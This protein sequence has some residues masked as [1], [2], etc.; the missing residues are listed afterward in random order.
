MT[1]AV[2]W[3]VVLCLS[4]GFIGSSALL[5]KKGTLQH[6]ASLLM[7]NEAQH[8]ENKNVDDGETPSIGA[9]E[10]VLD[11]LTGMKRRLR[12]EQTAD[13]GSNLGRAKRCKKERVKKEKA[14]KEATDE[15]SSLV[16]DHKYMELIKSIGAATKVAMK[17]Y[18]AAN[19]KAKAVSP[20]VATEK[21][22]VDALNAKIRAKQEKS[23]I[24]DDH[25]KTFANKVG[26]PS[27]GK[28]L[29][30]FKGDLKTTEEGDVVALKAEL[31]KAA[32]AYNKSR[33]ELDS[34]EHTMKVALKAVEEANRASKLMKN[35]HDTSIP[36][37]HELLDI[38]RDNSDD[39][40]LLNGEC[41]SK[42]IEFL[43]R[44]QSRKEELQ[45]MGSLVQFLHQQ[46]SVQRQNMADAVEMMKSGNIN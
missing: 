28:L 7:A 37:R 3:I 18:D 29:S 17:H 39:L 42:K 27:V 14:V 24:M 12:E 1:R 43:Q 2:V 6:G 35:R 22:V 13:E 36:R 32:Q 34:H 16:D 9:L 46:L 19:E 4:C 23:S 30:Q 33:T 44:H 26:S 40:K 25:L 45:T 21:Q 15:I 5:S 11:M 31:K 41:E 10:H 8:E 38:V 20:T